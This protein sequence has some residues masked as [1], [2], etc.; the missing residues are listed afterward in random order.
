[1]SNDEAGFF[2][3]LSG[4]ATEYVRQKRRSLAE[5]DPETNV[6]STGGGHRYNFGGQEIGWDDLR[7]IKNIRDSGGQVAQLMTYKALLNFG[8]GAEIHVEDDEQTTQSVAGVEM[9]LSECP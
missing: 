4:L 8:E 2:R 3:N 1:M 5:G 7:N 9:T 6:D